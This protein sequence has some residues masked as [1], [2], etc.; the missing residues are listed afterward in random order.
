MVRRFELLRGGTALGAVTLDPAES[1]FPW[2]VGWLEPGPAYASVEP[3]FAE[4]DRLWEDD[5]ADELHDRV[6]G[7]GVR[8][9]SLTDGEASEVVGINI[10]GSRV[11]WRI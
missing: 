8:M 6:M 4:L 1:D 3:L 7:P 10:A 2:F 5:E 9:R 11:C